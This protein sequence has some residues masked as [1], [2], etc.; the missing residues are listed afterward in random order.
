[1]DKKYELYLDGVLATRTLT[2]GKAERIASQFPTKKAEVF[3]ILPTVERVLMFTRE[4]T[5]GK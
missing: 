3:K 4:A 2:S 1:M 5:N